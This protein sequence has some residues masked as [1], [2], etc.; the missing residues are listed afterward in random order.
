MFHGAEQRVFKVST[1]EISGLIEAEEENKF[2]LSNNS[3]ELKQNDIFYGDFSS[4]KISTISVNNNKIISS[5]LINF[6]GINADY[7]N[8]RPDKNKIL[9]INTSVSY[10]FN[11]SAYNN[12]F[13]TEKNKDERITYFP[14]YINTPIDIAYSRN[15]S[16][17]LLPISTQKYVDIV[18]PN[19]TLKQKFNGPLAVL[20]NNYTKMYQH[21]WT[22]STTT[23]EDNSIPIYDLNF[24]WLQTINLN[25]NEN[26]RAFLNKHNLLNFKY[27]NSSADEIIELST[28]VIFN[29]ETNSLDP[30][31]GTCILVEN[32]LNILTSNS[33]MFNIEIC[34]KIMHD[35]ISQLN[36]NSVVRLLSPMRKYYK[37]K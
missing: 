31:K 11:I 3:N 13:N 8:N 29:N 16:Y 26:V 6:H 19:L 12:Q 15:Q 32:L 36:V 18:Q 33:Y 28:K 24:S 27:F 4:N 14:K 10:W 2:T 22:Q 37:I 30:I 25:S 21:Q 7:I 23:S 17:F 35:L 1:F 34:K 9:S 5:Y 20:K